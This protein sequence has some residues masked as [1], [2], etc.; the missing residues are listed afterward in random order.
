LEISPLPGS[1]VGEC[2]LRNGSFGVEHLLGIEL[3]ET[4]FGKCTTGVGFEVFLE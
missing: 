4:F 2:F 3:L 1:F